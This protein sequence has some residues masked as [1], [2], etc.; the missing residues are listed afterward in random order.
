MIARFLYYFVI[1][2]YLGTRY[3]LITRSM[4]LL[5]AIITKMIARENISLRLFFIFEKQQHRTG[6]LAAGPNPINTNT[7]LLSQI[8][9]SQIKFVLTLSVFFYGKITI[10]AAC[11]TSAPI[12]ILKHTIISIIE[13]LQKRHFF[14][15]LVIS[16]GLWDISKTH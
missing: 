8:L 9:S 1:N 11:Q 7:Y 12:F 16:L 13:A 6:P 10:S 5:L 15:M 2:V 4:Y 3:M 14:M